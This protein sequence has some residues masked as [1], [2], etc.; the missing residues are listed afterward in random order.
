MNKL[1]PLLISLLIS[2][3][4]AQTNMGPINT[5]QI[6][7]TLYVGSLSGSEFYPTIQS[8]VTA[9]CASG[10]NRV[11]DIPPAYT[12]SD[13][14][15]GVTGGCT[16]VTLRDEHFG[17]PVS[18][19]T[20]QTSVYSSSGVACS[21]GVTGTIILTPATNNYGISGSIVTTTG[22]ISSS[23]YS[24]TV[25]SPAGWI[26]GMGIA[27]AGAGSGGSLLVTSVSSIAGSVF[28]LATAAS[29]TV[30]GA[31]V[32]HNDTAAINAGISAAVSNGYHSVFLGTGNYNVTSGFTDSIGLTLKGNGSNNT[33]IYNRSSTATVFNIDYGDSCTT[34][35]TA[36]GHYSDFAIYQ[37]SDVTPTS[38]GGLSIGTGDLTHT[39]CTIGLN[40]NNI[41][42]YGLYNARTYVAGQGFIF[43][44]NV[45]AENSVHRTLYYNSPIPNG[46]DFFD[47]DEAAGTG[48]VEIHQS[49]TVE[50]SNLK[51]NGNHLIFS[52]PSAASDITHVRFIDPSFESS[53]TCAVD[54]GTNLTSGVQ[55]IGG[56]MSYYSTPT[57]Y[58]GSPVAGV[59]Y[60][61]VGTA[62]GSGTQISGILDGVNAHD[63][64][65]VDQI[66]AAGGADVYG[67]AAAR[68][69]VGSCTTGQYGTATTTSGLTC[70]Q[71]A[72]SQIS[73]TPTI[74]TWGSLNYPTWSSGTPFVKMTAAGTFSLDTNTYLT[75]SGIS[76]MTAGQVPIA[77]T[78][79]TITSSKALAGSG[80]A[81]TTG[82]TSSTSGDLVVYTGSGGQTADSGVLASS[83]LTS[84]SGA[85]LLAASNIMTGKQFFQDA[86]QLS[87]NGSG[88]GYGANLV[89]DY[90][91]NTGNA[92]YRDLYGT[93]S[94]LPTWYIR[95]FTSTQTEEEDYLTLTP[96][97]ATFAEPVAMPSGSTVNGSAICTANGTGGPQCGNNSNTTNSFSNT[98]GA[99]TSDV[100][101]TFNWPSSHWVTNACTFSPV[102]SNATNPAILAYV[103]AVQTGTSVVVTLYH[104]ATVA[105]G[106]SWDFICAA[107]YVP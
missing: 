4:F 66:G 77:A 72:Y 61:V 99:G 49:D 80:A 85:A 42:L 58:C 98:T 47:S 101:A 88:I 8:A 107:S 104:A 106:A 89:N 9:A 84:L 68:A 54:F 105:N 75:S 62:I 51:L 81:I 76:G 19:Y 71:V 60:F 16:A 53:P 92:V 24:L 37:A 33:I 94:V 67:A 36:G 39:T 70:A 15:S 83:V 102:N 63:A 27:V 43:S 93:S 48:D 38:G 44:K 100:V 73:G 74:G 26:S 59:N 87:G 5:P 31:T 97:A 55:F 34:P 91:Y 23:S 52:A 11:V 90:E 7:S 46:D 22:G 18:C 28:T 14:I 69:A 56:F 79:T 57:F 41:Y 32:W 6:N 64:V 82:T 20:W 95:A 12:G 29:T 40:L 86:T 30:S 3:C 21:G 78:G 25:A 17:L 10:S 2:P 1:L 96:T 35:P 65:A 45:R 13:L 50:Y 103:D